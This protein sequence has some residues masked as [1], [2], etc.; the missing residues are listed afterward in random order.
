M[1]KILAVAIPMMLL[2]GAVLAQDTGGDKNKKTPTE[3]KAVQKTE[4]KKA[5]AASQAN[6]VPA[7]NPAEKTALNPQPLPPGPQS[8]G[9][10]SSAA[11]KVELNPQPLPPGA[12]K[13]SVSAESKTALNPQPLP[14][15]AKQPSAAATKTTGQ[16]SGAA[17]KSKKGSAEASGSTTPK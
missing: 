6:P 1:K 14:P 17:A 16:K 12:K 4:A 7:K 9:Q 11:S 8:A 2:G 3:T 10:K 5:G 15:G 13:G